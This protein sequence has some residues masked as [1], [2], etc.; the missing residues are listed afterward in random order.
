MQMPANHESLFTT[1]NSK[2]AGL[3]GKLGALI[4]IAEHSLT[5]KACESRRWR[6][7]LNFTVK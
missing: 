4:D 3:D 1:R 2:G 5:I 6:D 7:L